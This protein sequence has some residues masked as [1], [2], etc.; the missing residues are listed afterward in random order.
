MGEV[1]QFTKGASNR[2][3]LKAIMA[4]Q[5]KN[6]CARILEVAYEEAVRRCNMYPPLRKY[7]HATATTTNQLITSDSFVWLLR[8]ALQKAEEQNR[9]EW[10]P[11]GGG[12]LP[13]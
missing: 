1:H 10:K 7:G 8:K 2:E 11:F 4:E 6:A 13:P 9:Q 3:V 12:L 5:E